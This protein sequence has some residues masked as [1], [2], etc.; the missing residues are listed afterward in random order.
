MVNPPE[1]P[2]A[3]ARV[4][5]TSLLGPLATA[6]IV[7]VFVVFLLLEHGDFRDRF[8][9]LV[10][11]GD[12]RTST[13][14]M[15]EAGKRVSR[16]L[17]VQ[18]TV[19]LSYG[20]LFG[21][22]MFLIGV[23]NPILWGLF[24]GLFR[25][26]PFVGTLIAA[27]IPFSLAFAIDPGWGMLI[28]AVGIFVALELV[29]TNAIEPRL[30]GSSTGLSPL[31]VIVAAMFWATLWGPIGLILATPLTVCLVV[32][33]RYVPQSHFLEILLGSEPVLV[34]EEQLYQRLISGNIEE[35]VEIA[36][37]YVAETSV[38]AFFDDIALPVLRLAEVDRGRNATDV[39]SRRLV[40]DGMAALVREFEPDEVAEAE[41][42]PLPLQILCIGGRTELDGAAASMLARVIDQPGIVCKVLPPISVRPEGIGHLDLAGID[43]V[44]LAYLDTNPRTYAK[45]V[46]KRIKRRNADVQVLACLLNAP[47]AL[48]DGVRAE[49]D[50][51]VG[52]S[53]A[54]KS[55]IV[56]YVARRD[57]GGPA[58]TEAPQPARREW[59][60]GLQKMIKSGPPFDAFIARINERFGSDMAIVS[61]EV[62]PASPEVDPRPDTG[63]HAVASVAA[64]ALQVAAANAPMVIEDAATDPDHTDDA[65]LLVNDL[66]FYAGVPLRMEDGSPIG[67]LSIMSHDARAFTP[68]EV[69]D[70]DAMGRQLM[71]NITPVSAHEVSRLAILEPG[72]VH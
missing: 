70:L 1:S 67:T 39:V 12:L 60:I 27:S 57:A 4:F 36:E 30:Y 33:G 40:A 41:E 50:G 65:F 6:A 61:P 5:L 18:F 23:P 19:N 66:R 46:A 45:F 26:I 37:N 32:L 35:A 62:H 14:V 34:R 49:L 8:L 31:A 53:S 43:I 58:L 72:S 21:L 42:G 56:D 11:R 9:K 2:L 3:F 51:V 55:W 15:N 13:K 29:I 63:G 16:Y 22:G 17:L 48:D 25:Y 10:S 44:C 69:A 20:I 7:T 59:T 47:A 68:D 71:S 38:D 24:A 64:L 52:N 54:A 28:W